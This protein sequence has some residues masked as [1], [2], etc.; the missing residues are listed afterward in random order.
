MQT[1]CIVNGIH[2]GTV[3]RH[4]VER[5]QRMTIWEI[6]MGDPQLANQAR[7]S[8]LVITEVLQSGLT[9]VECAPFSSYLPRPP[10]EAPL[11]RRLWTSQPL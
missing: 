3:D 6:R 2:V 11:C 10:Q 9:V 1:K 8:D 5:H 7:L 4:P